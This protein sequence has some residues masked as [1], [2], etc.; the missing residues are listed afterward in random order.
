MR[1]RIVGCLT[2]IVVSCNDR[3]VDHHHGPDW[4]L[5]GVQGG[6]SLL[7]RRLHGLVVVHPRTVDAGSMRTSTRHD[8]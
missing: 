5:A 2:P 7:E 8:P 6:A 4:H 3:A 1:R